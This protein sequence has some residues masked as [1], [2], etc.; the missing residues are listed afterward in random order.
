MKKAFSTLLTLCVAL[1]LLAITPITASAAT[2]ETSTQ[3]E[4]TSA[5]SAAASGDTIK[6]TADINYNTHMNIVGKNITFDLNGF[7]LNATAGLRV[8]S[9]KLLLADPRN[10]EF[11]VSASHPSFNVQ[12]YGTST[13][14]E[15]TSATTATANYA[16]YGNAGETIVYGDVTQNNGGSADYCGVWTMNGNITVKGKITAAGSA[17]YTKFGPLGSATDKAQA[18]YTV[19]STK[20]GYFTYTHGTYGSVWVKDPD[21]VPPPEPSKGIFG[22]KP[23]YNKWYHYILFF[24]GFG[25][26]WMWF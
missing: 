4:L 3:A 17:A 24:L 16:V 19:P 14:A 13:R 5:L 15:I 23:Q 26:I 12:V 7:K 9:C 18:E 10:G 2:I 20:T 8:E 22:T 11:N 6:L 21:Y 1:G 25:F